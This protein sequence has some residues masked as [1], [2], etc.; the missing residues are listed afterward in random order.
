[1]FGTSKLL[2]IRDALRRWRGLVFESNQYSIVVS[3]L[4]NATRRGWLYKPI[5]A[6]CVICGDA[7]GF[8]RCSLVP[9]VQ[10]ASTSSHRATRIT[11]LVQIQHRIVQ[12]ASCKVTWPTRTHAKQLGYPALHDINKKDLVASHRVFLDANQLQITQL[13]HHDLLRIWW[14]KCP[15]LYGAKI[16]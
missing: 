16:H 1:V 7:V 4:T 2:Q 15:V 14:L 13:W 10:P 6:G 8:R 12:N 9:I 11:H 3:L 5:D